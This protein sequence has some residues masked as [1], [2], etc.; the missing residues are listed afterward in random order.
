[1]LLGVEPE[2]GSCAILGILQFSPDSFGIETRS[3][4]KMG[5]RASYLEFP[6]IVVGDAVN[7][8]ISN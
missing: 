3:G 1:M 4:E 5:D 2:S 8:F 6:R 7:G